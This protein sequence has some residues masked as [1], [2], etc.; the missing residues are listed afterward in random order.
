VQRRFDRID[1]VIA[2]IFFATILSTMMFNVFYGVP[3]VLTF[4]LGLS[5][6]FLVGRMANTDN[7]Q[8]RILEYI[9]QIEYDTLLFFLGILLLVGMLKEV[10]VL[11]TVAALYSEYDPR[12]SNYLAG[13]IS[14]I[15]DNVPLT[16]ALLKASPELVTSEWLALTYAVGVGGSLLAIGSAAGIIV[17]SKVK[18]LTFVSYLRYTPMLLVAYSVGYA[19]TL[20]IAEYL[21]G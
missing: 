5:V 15:L 18:E 1:V 3:P 19:C 7:E 13:A 9:R 20:V 12:Y 17:M 21:Y 11:T 8:T 10:G 14:A 6:M 4:L 2:A 16:A